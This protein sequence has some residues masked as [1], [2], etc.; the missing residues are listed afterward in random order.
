MK[1][2]I[3]KVISIMKVNLGRVESEEENKW[4]FTE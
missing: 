3:L 1:A 4:P 2:E